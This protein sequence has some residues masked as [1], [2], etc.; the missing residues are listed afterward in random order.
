MRSIAL[1]GEVPEMS[2]QS[3]EE[4]GWFH[5]K[6]GDDALHVDQRHIALTTLHA[7]HVA[8]IQAAVM[9]K[10]FLRKPSRASALTHGLPKCLEHWRSV[11]IGH[12]FAC[13]GTQWLRFVACL[14]TVQKHTV[15]AITVC[16]NT[17]LSATVVTATAFADTDYAYH[18]ADWP[19]R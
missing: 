2:I 8:A 19:E 1:Y 4:F 9:R 6:G 18:F 14:A 15:I 7:T 16:R 12:W 5:I 11:C 3:Q 17:A 13:H 10:T